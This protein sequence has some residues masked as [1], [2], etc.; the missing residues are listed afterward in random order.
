MAG[1]KVHGIPRSACTMRVL[2][3]LLEKDV[4]FELVP[5][6]LM[7]GEH[8]QPPFLALQ[9]FGL[10]PVF[11]D[12]D[13]TLFESRAIARY[14]AEKYEKQSAS[15]YGSSVAERALIEQWI[16]VEGQIYA[17]AG[18]PIFY[19]LVIG[20]MRGVPTDMAVVEESLVKFEKVLDIYDE[21]LGKAPYLAGESFSL[22]DLT[23]MPLTQYLMNLP[24]VAPAFH[25]RKNVMAWWD[26]ISARP[27]W[28]K[29]IAMSSP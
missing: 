22:A 3:T 6:N 26:K 25:A 20:P 27:A 21:R 19:Q 5:V 24:K 18:H 14:V 15:L 2:A 28:K 12:E 23:H 11:Q 17:P 4:A 10:I 16:E 9:P 8:K 13:L 29:V 7:K 1:V